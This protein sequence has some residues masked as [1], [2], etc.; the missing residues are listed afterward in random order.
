[1]KLKDTV[2]MMTSK[3]E[4]ERFK[5]EYIQAKIRLEETVEKMKALPNAKVDTK[6]TL[7]PASLHLHRRALTEYLRFLERIAEKNRIDLKSLTI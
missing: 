3:D 5:A 7:S 4:Y 2:T 6:G 1:M